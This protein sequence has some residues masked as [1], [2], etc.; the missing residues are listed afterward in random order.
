[1]PEKASNQILFLCILLIAPIAYENTLMRKC[2]GGMPA[3]QNL[4]GCPGLMNV[5][6]AF[7][8]A[9]S[10]VL[11]SVAEKKV[12]KGG[13]MV[14]RPDSGDPVEAV[15]AALKAAEKVFGVD[16]NAKGY[17]VAPL[18]LLVMRHP[19]VRGLSGRA[20]CEQC[21]WDSESLSA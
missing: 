6:G 16:V 20:G 1:M 17:K 11:P 21:S 8:Q 12:G 3:R 2:L 14:L 7:A 10:E 19:Q 9:L 15:L 4:Q 13:F 5:R 18:M